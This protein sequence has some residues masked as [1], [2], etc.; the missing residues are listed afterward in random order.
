MA[1]TRPKDAA[2]LA[3][4]FSDLQKP[5]RPWFL[6]ENQLPLLRRHAN[7]VVETSRRVV[8]G[9]DAMARPGHSRERAALGRPLPGFRGRQF[10]VRS[11]R[12]AESGPA[13]PCRAGCRTRGRSVRR[14]A[15]SAIGNQ[16]ARSGNRVSFFAERADETC[17]PRLWKLFTEGER[18]FSGER[19]AVLTALVRLNAPGIRDVLFA[20]LANDE[21]RPALRHLRTLLAGTNDQEVIERI[22]ERFRKERPGWSN[23]GFDCALAVAAIGGSATL[24]VVEQLTEGLSE[25]IRSEARLEA[26]GITLDHALDEL[27]SLGIL[28][29]QQR[30]RAKAKSGAR[31]TLGGRIRQALEAAGVLV[32]FDS[33]FSG[34]PVPHDRLMLDL[35]SLAEDVFSLETA[36]QE[37]PLEGAEEHAYV[38]RFTLASR[39]YEFRCGD[40][41]DWYDYRAVADA[42]NRA[43][44]DAGIVQRFFELGADGQFISFIFAAPESAEEV[45]RRGL[46]TLSR[47]PT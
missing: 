6:S 26:R 29:R 21:F 2:D 47:P 45:R 10:P 17:I 34:T 9:A 39:P 35:A 3:R 18:P 33:E 36:S 7:E 46:I 42:L 12:A 31:T 38:V 13:R 44:A 43:L 25:E 19:D 37:G 22:V 16:D 5:M 11:A 15:L 23:V 41:S 20:D 1:R 8:E 30:A 24:P 14:G 27:E 28:D 40:Q 4:F 32:R